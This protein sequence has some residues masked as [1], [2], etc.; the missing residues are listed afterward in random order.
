MPSDN[1][2]VT[3]LHSTP[4]YS[5]LHGHCTTASTAGDAHFEEIYDG[6]GTVIMTTFSG[7][8]SSALL[9]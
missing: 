7:R 5:S 6:V 8:G 3:T 1:K 4:A 9:C 2:A